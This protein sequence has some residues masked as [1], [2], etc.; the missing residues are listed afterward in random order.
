MVPLS[1]EPGFNGGF[2]RTKLYV[3]F[4]QGTAVC[5]QFDVGRAR[6]KVTRCKCEN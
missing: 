1:K 3:L 4:T 5:P 6:Q 2:K